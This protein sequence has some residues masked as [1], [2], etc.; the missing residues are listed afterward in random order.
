MRANIHEGQVKFYDTAKGFGFVECNDG[1][2]IYIN[3]SSV[4]RLLVG[5]GDVVHL[6][7]IEGAD[8]KL[9]ACDMRHVGFQ[10]TGS[11]FADMIK[12]IPPEWWERIANIAEEEP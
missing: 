6:R 5:A 7:I 8:G 10:Q 2:E 1:T 11:P 9:S 12:P 3:R 4:G